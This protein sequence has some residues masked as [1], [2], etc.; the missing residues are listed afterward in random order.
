[1]EPGKLR[2]VKCC[3]LFGIDFVDHVIVGDSGFKSLK[4]SGVF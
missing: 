4:E 2:F 1:V 3:Q